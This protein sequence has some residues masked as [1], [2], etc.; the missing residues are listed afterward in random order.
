MSALE[1]MPLVGSG[2]YV[3]V[4]TSTGSIVTGTLL[5]SFVPGHPAI[6]RG[7]NTGRRI[8]VSDVAFITT[9]PGSRSARTFYV[10]D[11]S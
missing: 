6:V 5:E 2:T 10:G 3:D 11:A 4:Q 8:V 1:G 9:A 7:P